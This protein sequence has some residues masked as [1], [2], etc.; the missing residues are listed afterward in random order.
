MSTLSELI[1]AF[2]AYAQA[3]CRANG[4]GARTIG[5][6]REME[7]V[8]LV[9]LATDEAASNGYVA[10]IAAMTAELDAARSHVCP[11]GVQAI[12]DA[13]EAAVEAVTES[14]QQAPLPPDAP[15]TL[16]EPLAND[17]P[18]AT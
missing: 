2:G 10:A 15:V 3:S 18:Q 12:D 7:S 17:G 4:A 6:L 14:I 11:L 13:K 1:S 8:I 5:K 9:Q 16:A